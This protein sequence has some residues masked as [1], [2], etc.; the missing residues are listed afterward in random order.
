MIKIL[1]SFLYHLN[2][3]Y[4]QKMT[5]NEL[6]REYDSQRFEPNER[7]VEY[8]FV[9]KSLL[10]ASPTTILDVGTGRSSLPHLLKICGFVVTAID[11]I[12]DY[13]TRP[14]FNRH[15]YLIN[16]DITKTKIKKKFDLITC[17]STLEHIKNYHAAI[18][19]MFRLLNPK[20]HLVLTFP[21]NEKK[22][23]ANV[24]KLPQAGFGKHVSYICRVYSRKQLDNWLKKNN[25]KIIKQ[26]YWQCWTGKFWTFGRER[27]PPC[28]VD[29]NK[30]HQLTCV[31]IQKKLQ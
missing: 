20:G 27:Y 10:R 29:K 23:I 28:K 11:N 12:S 30:K 13:W 22:Y 18:E 21:Y 6:K 3:S 19:S 25:G 31:L 26:E 8:G 5:K 24:Y 7:I 2:Q 1:K 17:V 14:I 9:F 16:D 15:F 4:C